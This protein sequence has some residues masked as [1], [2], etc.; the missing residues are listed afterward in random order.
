MRNRVPILGAAAFVFCTACTSAAAPSADHD[1]TADERK[2][3]LAGLET[4]WSDSDVRTVVER[5]LVD[6]ERFVTDPEFRHQVTEGLPSALPAGVDEE[7][8]GRVLQTLYS[9]LGGFSFEQ[10]EEIETAWGAAPRSSATRHGT[11]EPPALRF[12]DDYAPIEASLLSFPSTIVDPADA[13]TL[14]ETIRERT[15]NRRL[16]V[17]ADLPMHR[18]LADEAERLDVT[19]LD[20]Y[21]RGYSPWP[22]DPFSV[23]IDP[24]QRLVLVERDAP[25]ARREEDHYM[26]REIVQ[27]LPAAL[28]ERWGEVRWRHADIFFHNGHILTTEDALWISIHALEIEILE[29]LGLDRVPVESFA[30]VDGTESYLSATRRAAAELGELFGRPVRFV[31]PLP[32]SGSAPEREAIMRTIGGGAG[33][34]LDSILTLV[35]SPDGGLTALVGDPSAAAELIATIPRPEW[36]TFRRLY[37]LR[38]PATALPTRLAAAQRSRRAEGLDAYLD[39]VAHHLAARGLEVRRSPL[40]LVPTD[41]LEGFSDLR[42]DEFVVGWQNVVFEPRPGGLGAEGFTSGLAT[43]DRRAR[44]LFESLGVELELLPSLPESVILNGGYRCASNQVRRPT[45]RVRL[46]PG[47]AGRGIASRDDTPRDPPCVA[48]SSPSAGAGA[49]GRADSCA[50]NDPRRSRSSAARSS[51]STAPPPRESAPSPR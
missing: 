24:R 7:L 21:G 35:P 2:R 44:R 3:L 17:L 1:A 31:H 8:R 6:P 38:S 9:D 36:E 51:R 29:D 25:Q 18:A 48:A 49:V 34:D 27:N 30:T 47:R 11:V 19:I 5:L 43:A 10:S 50:G 46:A 37:G 42:H 39:L 41:L 28:D 40:L 32:A 4:P 22:R 13:R 33:F 20:T 12:A 16:V 23:G 14:L 45:G 15:P 26:A